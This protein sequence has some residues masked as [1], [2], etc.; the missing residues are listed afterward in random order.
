M[1]CDDFFL[2]HASVGKESFEK[3]LS[4]LLR[5]ECNYLILCNLSSHACGA[6]LRRTECLRLKG[7]VKSDDRAHPEPVRLA[8]VVEAAVVEI[9]IPGAGPVTLNG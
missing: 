2:T 3:T 4:A 8:A 6:L 7:E 9:A 1:R 5:G